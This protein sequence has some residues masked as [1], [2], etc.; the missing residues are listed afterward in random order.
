MQQWTIS[1]STVT[2][3]EKWIL[4]RQP[5]MTSS[6][7]RLRRSSKA[8][9][10]GKLA[11]KNSSC[12]LLGGLLPIW[13]IKLSEFQGNHYIWEV[14]STNQWHAP[15]PPML[16]A[17]IGLQTNS[18]AWQLLKIY[19]TTSSLKVQQ[20]GLGSFASSTIFIWPLTNWLLLL[21]VSHK[22]LQ[23]KCFPNQHEAKNTFQEF[24]E[25]GSMDLYAIGIN[26]LIS[27]WQK[28]VDC[29]DSNFH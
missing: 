17:S 22:F 21:Q 8:L 5:V 12:L 1:Q 14:C 28:C 25:T 11:P 19:N 26:K 20:I 7:I 29:N 18:S 3:N 6:V 16:T 2:W 23:R 9:L 4:I 13:P 10:K 24:F 27:H 15:K